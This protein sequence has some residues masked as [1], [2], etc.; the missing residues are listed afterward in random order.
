MLL[1][2]TRS[3]SIGDV[4]YLEVDILWSEVTAV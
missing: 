2:Y 1:I 3:I 4:G